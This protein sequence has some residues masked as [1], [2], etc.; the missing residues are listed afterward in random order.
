MPLDV[1]VKEA[2][3]L[4]DKYVD[5]VVSY[6][7]FL[8]HQAKME[9]AAQFSDNRQLGIMAGRFHSIAEDFDETPDCFKEYV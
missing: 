3:G 6:I 9:E 4:Q 5:M 8:Q 7:R 2:T 1:M